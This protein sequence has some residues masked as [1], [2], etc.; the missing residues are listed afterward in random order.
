M[1]LDK[2][3][4]RIFVEKKKGFDIGAEQLFNDLKQVLGI[5]ELEEVRVLSRY[6]IQGLSDEVY[7]KAKKYIFLEPNIDLVYE[8]D[9]TIGKEY[10]VLELSTFLDN[11]TREQIPLLNA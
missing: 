11:T 4:R 8:E 5:R 6:D 3:V 10:K 9:L 2:Q 1:L 7:E